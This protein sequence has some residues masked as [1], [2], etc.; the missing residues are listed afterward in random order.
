MGRGFDPQ[1]RR[2]LTEHGC[3]FIRQGKGSHKIWESP[4]TGKRFS[5]PV[6]VKSRFTANAILRQAG[7]DQK[8]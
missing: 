7:I 8:F 6:T 3:R 5:V 4:I 2:L 1:V